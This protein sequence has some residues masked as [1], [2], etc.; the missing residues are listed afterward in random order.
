MPEMSG[1]QRA[2]LYLGYG[3]LIA[4]VVT[5]ALLVVTR[6]PAGLPV[7]LQ[8]PPTPLPVRVDVTGA[9]V[10]PGVYQLPPNSIVQ[11]ALAAA[12]GATAQADLSLLNLAHRLQDGDQVVVPARLPTA[13]AGD[14]AAA[15]TAPAGTRVPV[16]PSTTNRL[17]INTAT[18]DQLVALPRIGPALAQRIV[19][20]RAAH[21]AFRAIEDIMQVAGIGPATFAQIKDLITVN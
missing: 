20:Y 15:G 17:N 11:D 2:L 5:G 1:R 6:R 13:P 10:S 9:V 3:L 21:G 8:A 12:G 16:A 4:L 19:D 7:Q 14:P 18:V